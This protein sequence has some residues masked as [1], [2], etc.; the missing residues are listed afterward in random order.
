MLWR[1]KQSNAMVAPGSGM[2]G[3]DVFFVFLGCLGGF[4][5]FGA[6]ITVDGAG[7]RS[8]LDSL[9]VFVSG[10]VLSLVGS[11]VFFRGISPVDLDSI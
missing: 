5:G 7:L 11:V 8:M 3:G 9:F 2:D 1:T 10:A 6:G 4:F